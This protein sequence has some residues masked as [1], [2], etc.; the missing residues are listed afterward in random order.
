VPRSSSFN[1]TPPSGSSVSA[2]YINV[3]SLMRR[4]LNATVRDRALTRLRP[5]LNRLF[6]N[7][8]SAYDDPHRLTVFGFGD[9]VTVSAAILIEGLGSIAHSHA[10]GFAKYTLIAARSAAFIVSKMSP[11]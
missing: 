7:G 4:I 8:V 3:L 9:A 6:V 11:G 5:K 1:S 2:R 10:S